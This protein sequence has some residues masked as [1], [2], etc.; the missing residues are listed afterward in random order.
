LVQGRRSHP[1]GANAARIGL[2][3]DILDSGQAGPGHCAM[4]IVMPARRTVDALEAQSKTL[5]T[6]HDG[7]GFHDQD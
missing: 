7:V 3:Y 6:V 2:A 5:L 1:S 4:W